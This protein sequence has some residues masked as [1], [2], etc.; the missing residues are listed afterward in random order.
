MHAVLGL[1]MMSCVAPPL[2]AEIF[3]CTA[4]DGMPRYQNFPCE[5]DSIGWSP[6][7]G[8]VAECSVATR[9]HEPARQRCI[10]HRQ[11][12][13]GTPATDWHGTRRAY[14]ALGRADGDRSTKKQP[15]DA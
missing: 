6:T 4:K 9:D 12:V 10:V 15:L 14:I 13:P 1:V 2:A 11:M 7:P 5:F 8:A 3:K